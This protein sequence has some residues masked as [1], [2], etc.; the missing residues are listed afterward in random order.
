LLSEDADWNAEFW[1][2]RPEIRQPLARALEVLTTEGPAQIAVQ[3]L[4]V[5]DSPREEVHL[6]AQELVALAAAGRLGTRRRYLVERA[7]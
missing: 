4:W 3:A 7:V 1:S 2:M 5:G 6:S